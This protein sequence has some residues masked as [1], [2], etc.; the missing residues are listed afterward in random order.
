MTGQRLLADAGATRIVYGDWRDSANCLTTD[1]EDFFPIPAN[2]ARLLRNAK[3][4]CAKCHVQ[5]ECL[6]L[7]ITSGSDTGV[8][9]GLSEDERRALKRRNRRNR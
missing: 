9:G 2:N 1:P 7:A 3:S 4:F 6:E 8:W 5:A